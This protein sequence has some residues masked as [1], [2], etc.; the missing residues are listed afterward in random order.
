[1]TNPN[2]EVF[3]LETFVYTDNNGQDYSRVYT[4]G[5]FSQRGDDLTTYYLTDYFE[6]TAEGSANLV[7]K[8]IDK[9]LAP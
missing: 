6:N 9:M 1:M 7:L 8:C 3:Y 4:L 2:W 5:F